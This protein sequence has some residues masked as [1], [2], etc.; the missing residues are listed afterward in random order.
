L[1]KESFSV[2]KRSAA[3]SAALPAS[4]AA[5]SASLSF[6]SGEDFCIALIATAVNV[7][8]AATATTIMSTHHQASYAVVPAI[9]IFPPSMVNVVPIQEIIGPSAVNA[10][11]NIITTLPAK[12]N[13]SPSSSNP[14]EENSPP[15]IDIPAPTPVIA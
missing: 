2:L 11:P 14:K 5:Y 4:S 12:A 9:A 15:S 6:A 10:P 1:F 13:P 3:S 8:K 7:T